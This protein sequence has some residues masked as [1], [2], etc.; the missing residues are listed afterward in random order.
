MKPNYKLSIF[1]LPFLFCVAV[2]GQSATSYDSTLAKKLG[3]DE[4]G[5]K[6]YVFVILKSGKNTITDKAKRDS[7]FR[8][9]LANIHR[10]ADNGDLVL[11]GPFGDN[12]NNYRGLFIFNAKSTEEIKK[13]LETDPAV[14]AGLFDPELYPW[15]GSAAVQQVNDLHKKVAKT[16]F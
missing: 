8:G 2:F 3:A 16:S 13:M 4:Y 11:A 10:L 5:M 1:V 14:K 9:H 7:I 15:Y 6:N 12:A